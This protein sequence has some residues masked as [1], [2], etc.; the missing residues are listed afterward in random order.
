MWK[1]LGQTQTQFITLLICQSFK[2]LSSIWEIRFKFASLAFRAFHRPACS[3]PEETFCSSPFHCPRQAL[4]SPASAVPSRRPLLLHTLSSSSLNLPTPQEQWILTIRQ[5]QGSLRLV[6][7]PLFRCCSK[8]VS[9]LAVSLLVTPAL[10]EH[11]S[12]GSPFFFG[13]HSMVMPLLWLLPRQSFSHSLF[14]FF[15]SFLSCFLNLI[16]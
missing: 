11:P 2:P 6:L 14:L 3:L 12:V 10:P 4:Q 7:G 5:G 16:F 15:H 13:L 8:S 9:P 1:C